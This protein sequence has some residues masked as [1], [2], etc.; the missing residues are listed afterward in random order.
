MTSGQST[1]FG[2]LQK[3]FVKGCDDMGWGRKA[4]L[5]CFGHIAVLVVEIHRQR[6]RIALRLI[7]C[8]LVGEHKAHARYPL[9]AFA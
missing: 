7:Q 9:Q 2:V 6:M 1:F 5:A 4:P 8:L 3:R